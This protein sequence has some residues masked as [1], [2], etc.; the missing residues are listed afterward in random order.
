MADAP[1]SPRKKFRWRLW[2]VLFPL[3]LIALPT[4]LIYIAG[5][6]ANHTRIPPELEKPPQ[7]FIVQSVQTGAITTASTTASTTTAFGVR[8]IPARHVRGATDTTNYD[9][10]AFLE[11]ELRDRPDL[12]GARKYLELIRWSD[13]TGT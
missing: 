12:E 3:L 8:L 13:E 4:F 5:I 6:C 11:T 7:I 10:P 2:L 1:E 9:Y